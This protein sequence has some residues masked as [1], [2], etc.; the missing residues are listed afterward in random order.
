MPPPPSRVS[1][2]NDEDL[3]MAMRN[4]WKLPAAAL[5]IAIGLTLYLLATTSEGGRTPLSELEIGLVAATLAL[6]VYGAQGLLSVALEGQEMRPGQHGGRFANL[7]S[8]VIVACSLALTTLAIALGW[9]VSNDWSP[10]RLGVLAGAGALMLVLLL[11]S[12]KE[13]FL[14]DEVCLDDREDG[15][16]W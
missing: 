6:A 2:R 9:G 8:V 16:P 11:V 4:S 10:R 3:T 13:A 7:A 5:I 12:Y 14:G 15:I 1:A